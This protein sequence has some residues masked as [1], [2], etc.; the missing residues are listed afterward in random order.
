[1]AIELT[2]TDNR[3]GTR[4]RGGPSGSI[5]VYAVKGRLKKASNSSK[6]GPQTVRARPGRPSKPALRESRKKQLVSATIDAIAKY[7][8]AEANIVRIAEIAGISAGQIHHYLG[9]RTAYSRPLCAAS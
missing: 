7:G 1:M 3:R 4:L 5:G 6:G 8:F 2:I 9:E